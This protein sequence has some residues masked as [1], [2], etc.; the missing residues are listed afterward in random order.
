MVNLNDVFDSATAYGIEMMGHFMA[1]WISRVLS[2]AAVFIWISQ[3]PWA[4]CYGSPSQVE[5]AYRALFSVGI[6]FLI[7][8][9]SSLVEARIMGF[10]LRKV[11]YLIEEIKLNLRTLIFVVSIVGSM[12]GLWICVEGGVYSSN[13]CF[14]AGRISRE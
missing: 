10:N 4:S 7:Q 14:Q 12:I 9:S 5:I 11:I 13:P 1:E 6:S 8:I 3:V 2:I